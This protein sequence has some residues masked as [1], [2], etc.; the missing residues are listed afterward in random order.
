M[1][2]LTRLRF[3]R[4]KLAQRVDRL[5]A[6]A[7]RQPREASA[8][9]F[10]LEA[11]RVVAGRYRIERILGEGGMGRV[12]FATDL[13]EQRQVAL[14]EMRSPPGLSAADKEESGLL[15]RKEFFAM[16]KLQHPNI[17][18]VFDA[19]V[20]ETG[21]RF[22]TMEVIRGVSLDTH[23]RK[24][25]KIS[26]S[27]TASFLLQL[28]QTLSFVHDRYYVHCDIKSENVQVMDGNKIKLMDF[29]LMHQLGLPS[30]QMRGTPAYMAPEWAQGGVIDGRADLYSLGIL[31]FYLV[32]GRY[33]F[34]ADRLSEMVDAHVNQPPPQP[35]AF[36]K[37]DPKLEAVLLRLLAKQPKDRFSSAGDLAQALADVLGIRLP[38]EPLS[39]RASYLH[40]SDVVGREREVVALEQVLHSAREG[41]GRS[42]FVAAPAGVG[43]SRLLQEFELKTKFAEIPFGAGFCRPE[44]L[45]PL[46]PLKQALLAL[47][48]VTPR[49]AIVEYGPVL[50][51]FLPALSY[52]DAKTFVD[53]AKEKMALLASLGDWLRAV[54]EQTPFVVCVED[55]HWADQASVEYLN[56]IIRALAGTRGVVCLT[57]RNNEL[58]RLSPAFQTVDEG[59]TDIIELAPLTRDDV[60]AIVVQVFHRLSVPIEFVDRL[61]GASQGNAFFVLEALRS[62]VEGSLFLRAGARWQIQGTLADVAIPSLVEDLVAARL[63]RLPDE[64]MQFFRRLA[65]AGRALPIALIRDVSAMPE[66]AAFG[67]LDEAVER[68]FLVYSE[69][70]YYFSHEIIRSTIYNNTPD[71]AKKQGH[72]SIASHL[73]KS[74]PNDLAFM[75]QVG[76][77]YRRSAAPER[78]ISPLIKAGDYAMQNRVILEAALAYKDACDLLEDPTIPHAGRDALVTELYGK[79]VEI[80][81]S[82]APPFC[83]QYCD[84]L[85]KSWESVLAHPPYTYNQLAE[86]IPGKLKKLVREVSVKSGMDSDEAFVK[87]AELRILQGIA[88]AA[89]G[90]GPRVEELV[91]TVGAEQPKGSP[92][93]AAAV[94]A[95][96]VY[97]F[98]LG[99]SAV[100]PDVEAVMADLRNLR[101]EMGKAMPRRL[102]W[103]LGLSEYV[104]NMYRATGGTPLLEPLTQDGLDIAEKLAFMDLRLHHLNTRLARSCFAGVAET[105]NA[106]RTE[107]S[108]LIRRMGE[109]RLL[110]KNF[111]VFIPIYFLERRELVHASAAA[112]RLTSFIPLMP[113]DRWLPHYAQTAEALARAQAEPS[114]DSIAALEKAVNDG[115]QAQFR[116]QGYARAGLARAHVALGNKERAVTLA[117]AALSRAMDPETANLFDEVV[118]RRAL[119][120]ALPQASAEH[121]HKAIERAAE[122]GLHIQEGAARLELAESLFASDRARAG[123]EV[124]QAEEIFEQFGAPEWLKTVARFRQSAS[125]G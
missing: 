56:A 4:L 85:F 2:L 75:R 30:K 70:Q 94:L 20:L 90:V 114:A 82:A 55:M 25:G 13:S 111:S 93:R 22:I 49:S 105:F 1:Q 29:G 99:K 83:V 50:G 122:N 86:L 62:W 26:S 69:G 54:A 8:P 66:D 107:T 46:A 44:G 78:A 34:K 27:D 36:A 80:G 17:V 28:A 95:Q 72:L 37:V 125:R 10:M 15:F 97:I 65:P 104:I 18:K 91:R 33:P 16:K 100:L 120:L 63:A 103:A 74:H 67:L 23:L 5:L 51:R 89:M 6:G 106:L 88:L 60:S 123:A 81:F 38:E 57:A 11:K 40:V 109:P 9:A 84:K 47:V 76:F 14:K 61:Y 79:L 3:I 45:A 64:G 48:P 42:V 7:Q 87:R 117:E 68:Q 102:Q 43:K 39:A 32:T 96:G 118:A 92:Y 108:D 24:A 58:S 101:D 21:D 112:E 19:G 113:T 110:T 41:K 52:G 121:L 73:E 12:W 31:G 77:H 98:H 119:A 124:Q 71:D 116:L 53:P 59:Y 35:S 115:D